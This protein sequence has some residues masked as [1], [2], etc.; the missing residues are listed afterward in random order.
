MAKRKTSKTEQTSSK[1][2]RRSS[3]K[4]AS[5]KT[6]APLKTRGSLKTSAPLKGRGFLKTRGRKK[7]KARAKRRSKARR[8]LWGFAGAVGFVV[9]VLSSIAAN[10]WVTWP[11]VPSLATDNPET[12][13]FIE[14]YREQQRDAN[15]SDRVG[16]HWVPWDAISIHMKRAVV[17]AEDIEFFSHNG[18]STTEI[19]A[20]IEEALEERKAPRGASTITQQLAKKSLAVTVTLT[21]SQ[22]Q[23][24][25]ADARAR[26][27]P[28][29][30]PYSRDL[31]EC[32]RVWCGDLRRRSRGASLLWQIG[33]C[34]N[35]ARVGNACGK[36]AAS[37]QLE[38]V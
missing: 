16:W 24:G 35:S 15:Q 10:Q 34:L 36:L 1:R 7:S 4:S 19:R 25:G 23:R 26:S 11:D 29:Q 28:Q 3:G 5:L 30:E 21:F 2:K 18:F 17:V 12:T 13:A 27:E 37:D 20:A 38:S 8:I 22:T 31:S 14:R 9:L 33:Q 32:R 6:S